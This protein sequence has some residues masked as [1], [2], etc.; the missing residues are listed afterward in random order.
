LSSRAEFIEEI[1]KK[2][3]IWR[4]KRRIILRFNQKTTK[5]F[6]S[7]Q[8]STESNNNFEFVH[9]TPLLSY[10][11]DSLDTYAINSQPNKLTSN[12]ANLLIVAQTILTQIF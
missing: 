5:F 7:V 12:T 1:K 9:R 8:T 10:S 6:R 3:P 4:F 11:L 2:Q